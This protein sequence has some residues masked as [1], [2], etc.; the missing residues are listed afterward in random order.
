MYLVLILLY[1]LLQSYAVI[2]CT[3]L[4][5]S[6]TAIFEYLIRIVTEEQTRPFPKSLFEFLSLFLSLYNVLTLSKLSSLTDIILATLFSL[7]LAFLLTIRISGIS[8]S[9][10]AFHLVSGL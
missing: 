8:E 6:V 2:I 3:V 7:V 4:I 1:T 9:T 10:F 5:P